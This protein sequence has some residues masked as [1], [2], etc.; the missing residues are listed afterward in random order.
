MLGREDKWINR[1]H[2]IIECETTSELSACPVMTH[3]VWFISPL[4]PIPVI[5]LFVAG[6]SPENEYCRDDCLKIILDNNSKTSV[7]YFPTRAK[8][9]QGDRELP[10]V[11]IEI[12]KESKVLPLQNAWQ[13]PLVIEANDS[14]S[15]YVSGFQKSKSNATLRGLRYCQGAKCQDMDLDNIRFETKWAYLYWTINGGWKRNF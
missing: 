9:K 11:A 3:R 7:Q 12:T 6:Y 4:I 5:P 1:D 14:L 2:Q 13:E 8:I 10:V 15:I